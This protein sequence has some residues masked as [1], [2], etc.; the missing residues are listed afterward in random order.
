MLSARQ[1]SF[2]HERFEQDRDTGP[3][4][5]HNSDES[6]RQ[7]PDCCL[8]TMFLGYCVYTRSGDV[9]ATAT[10]NQ[11][12]SFLDRQTHIGGIVRR[13]VGRLS[14]TAHRGIGAARTSV[15]TGA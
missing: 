15:N 10:V 8:K 3:G 2:E 12:P 6:S 13:R 7:P 1:A 4:G 9:M 11:T 5:Q 14:P